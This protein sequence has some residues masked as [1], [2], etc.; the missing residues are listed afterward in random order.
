MNLKDAK[1]K[2]KLM[3]FISLREKTHPKASHA[4]FHGTIKA[5]AEG[6]V[7]PKRGTSRKASRGS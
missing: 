6:T 5:M 7:K 3:E 2:N 4:H 1:A